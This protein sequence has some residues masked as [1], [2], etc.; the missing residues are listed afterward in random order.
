MVN[1]TNKQ[2]TT[3]IIKELIR[4]STKSERQ[5]SKIIG[6]SQPTVSRIKKSLLDQK[7]IQELIAIP[8][9][10]K[11]GYELMAINFVKIKA[12][13]APDEERK[14]NFQNVQKWMSEQPN[15]IFCSYCKGLDSDSFFISV[16]KNYPEFDEF[17]KNHNNEMGHLLAQVKSSLVNLKEN[18]TIKPFN[19]KYLAENHF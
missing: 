14:Q 12:A 5:I 19:F 18:Q 11:I 7:I 2:T 8:N 10:D 13:L 3:S 9:F 6:V 17:I 1:K 4:D 16:H 15:V